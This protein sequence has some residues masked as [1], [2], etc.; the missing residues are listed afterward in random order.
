MH[1][2]KIVSRF[3]LAGAALAGAATGVLAQGYPAKPIRIIS[4]FPTG[5]SPDTAMR[6][7]ADKLTGQF[8]QGVIV[9]PRPGGNGFIAIGAAKQAPADGHTLLLISNAHAAINPNLFASVPYDMEADFVPVSTIY[10]APFFLAVSA[11]GPFQTLPQLIAAA[12]ASPERITY[13]TPYVGSPP[14]LAGATLAHLTDTSMLAV[15][16]KEGAQIY[17]SV[18]NGDVHFTIATLGTLAPLARAGKLKI[19]A[20]AAPARIPSEPGIPTVAEA[21]GPRDLHVESWL[22]L[23]APRG[24]PSEIVRRLNESLVKALAE[25]DVAE[26]FRGQGLVPTSAAPEEM[27]RLIREDGKRTR[28]LIKRIGIKAE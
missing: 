11:N 2:L 4:A 16:F 26:R 28:D 25:P 19:L 3:A 17:S 13:S 5:I 15:H 7:A 22:G 23:V 10:R 18:A 20:I 27:A 9:E 24:T 6:I 14:H 21:G 1:M 8:K 12:K